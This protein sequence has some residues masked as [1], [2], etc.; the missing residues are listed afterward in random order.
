MDNNVTLQ[1]FL[2][3]VSI[4]N[5]Y[6]QESTTYRKETVQQVIQVLKTVRDVTPFLKRY[7]ALAYVS[8]VLFSTTLERQKDVAK[9]LNVIL[10][11][12]HLKKNLS[13]EFQEC[14]AQRHKNRGPVKLVLTN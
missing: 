12:L 11:D 7:G 10:N 5:E 3:E 6:L 9:M 2:K 4:E 14:L 1:E 13:R 8:K